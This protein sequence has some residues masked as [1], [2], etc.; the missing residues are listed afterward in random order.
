M[1]PTLRWTHVASVILCIA[2]CQGGASLPPCNDDIDC[3]AGRYCAPGRGCDFECVLDVDCTALGTCDARGRCRPAEDAGIGATD[4]GTSHDAGDEDGGVVGGPD[5]G[6]AS[7]GDG[8]CNGGEN[9]SSCCRDCGCA[10]GYSCMGSGCVPDPSCGDGACNGEESPASC[11]GDCGCASG[12]SCSGASCVCSSSAVRLQN[13]MPDSNQYCFATGTSY[14]QQSTAYINAGS[15]WVYMPD[16][17]WA[18]YSAALGG[19]FTFQ[20]QCCYIDGCLGNLSC[21]VPGA[22]NYPCICAATRTR[23]VSVAACGVNFVSVCS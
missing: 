20:E 11:C 13:V 16:G 21:P 4:G 14:T 19:T 8:A 1:F 2:G 17:G 3:G 22:G 7:C 9:E 10:S 12:Y 6:P 23:T 18:D 15:G 5:A